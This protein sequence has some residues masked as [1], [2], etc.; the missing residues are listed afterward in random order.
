MLVAKTDRSTGLPG[1]DG[2]GRQELAMGRFVPSREAEPNQ[3]GLEILAVGGVLSANLHPPSR[4]AQM[5]S[6]NDV[7]LLRAVKMA[8]IMA[9]LL[10]AEV[11]VVDPLGV[12]HDWLVEWACTG[13]AGLADADETP[14]GYGRLS[15]SSAPSRH[16]VLHAPER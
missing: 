10:D 4:S 16:T 2:K 8:N 1:W 3:I 5:L 12:W 13:Q 9:R 6:F 15:E 11:A 7:P 14:A